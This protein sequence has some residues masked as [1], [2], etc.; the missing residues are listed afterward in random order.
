MF[1]FSR[2]TLLLLLDFPSV[3]CA[4]C[5]GACVL[6]SSTGQLVC[7]SAR[8]FP[9]LRTLAHAAACQRYDIGLL[10]RPLSTGDQLTTPN[11]KLISLRSR[12]RKHKQSL[13]EAAEA[14]KDPIWRPHQLVARTGC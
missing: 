12:T 5:V 7:L 4:L 8:L 6:P 9:P 13:E 2:S 1:P 3:H 14:P 10:G 11:Q